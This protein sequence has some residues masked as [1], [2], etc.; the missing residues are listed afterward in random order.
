MSSFV[1]NQSYMS[2]LLPF[3]IDGAVLCVYC[4]LRPGIDFFNSMDRAGVKG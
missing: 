1:L 4:K 3:I 2:F